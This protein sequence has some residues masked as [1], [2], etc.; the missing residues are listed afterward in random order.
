LARMRADGSE[1]ELQSAGP[2]NIWGL[3]QARNGEVFLQEANDWGIPVVEFENGTNYI[4]GKPQYLRPYAP[5]IPATLPG[6]QMGG[7]GLSGLALVEDKNSPFKM[8]YEG[9]VFY[10][11]NP[12]TNRLQIVTAQVDDEGDYTY[13]KQKDFLL[14]DD[15]LFRPVAAH[16]GPDSCLYVSDWYNLVISHN[17]VARDH[18]DRDKKH[19]RIWRICADSLP[20]IAPPN[21]TKKSSSELLDYLDDDNALVARMAWQELADRKDVKLVTRLEKLILNTS[22]PTETRTHALWA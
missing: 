11:V 18:P 3:V 4:S 17:E 7:T 9:K 19:G 2:N 10:L 14:S 5:R 6:N 1:F 13:K 12:I 20:S 21:L 22:I 15:K 8:G 16:F